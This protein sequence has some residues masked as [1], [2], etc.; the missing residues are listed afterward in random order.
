MR[1]FVCSLSV[2]IMAVFYVSC[3]GSVKFLKIEEQEVSAPSSGGFVELEINASGVTW[4]AK[5]EDNWIT[6]TN[7]TGDG[8]DELTMSI[9]A[10]ELPTSRIGTVN[11]SAPGMPKSFNVKVK[12][13]AGSIIVTP[14]EKSLLA[15]GE[16]I[17][18]TVTADNAVSWTATS[19]KDWLTLKDEKATGNGV[20]KATAIA[21]AEA[22]RSAKITI[23]AKGVKDVV[24][25][26]TQLAG[27]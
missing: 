16:I 14:L 25:E 12:Q 11:I 17:D 1:K 21:N 8:D 22:S 7:P 9:L 10:S 27:N 4:V 6:F 3:E 2:A 15:E 18:I 5:T 20:I 26:I 23:V 19:D 13:A 24:V